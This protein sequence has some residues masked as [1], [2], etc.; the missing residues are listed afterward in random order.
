[1][2]RHLGDLWKDWGA[3]SSRDSY[4]APGRPFFQLEQ[5]EDRIML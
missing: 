4:T 5:L 2:W 3:R 1:M